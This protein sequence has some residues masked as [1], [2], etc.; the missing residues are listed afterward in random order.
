MKTTHNDV[1]ELQTYFCPFWSLDIQAA[2]R[3]GEEVW[4]YEH[5]LFEIIDNTRIHFGYESFD[6]IDPVASILEHIL[7]MARNKIE[8]VTS[9]DFL[10]DFSGTT[11]EIY[12]HSN[13][14]CSSYDWWQEARDELKERTQPYINLLLKDRW[15]KYFLWELEI[16]A[17]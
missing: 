15:C 1:E 4:L 12:T 5:E 9:Y 7:Q 6:H 11:S 13:F 2:C 10:N 17:D 14:M 16:G 8:E 3:I